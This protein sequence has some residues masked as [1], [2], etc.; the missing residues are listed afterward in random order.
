[1]EQVTGIEPVSQP[2]QGCIIAFIL[3]LHKNIISKMNLISKHINKIMEGLTGFEPAIKDLQ[4]YAL[5]LGYSPV[6]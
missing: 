6:F 2:W 1:M 5:P 3:H 4:S